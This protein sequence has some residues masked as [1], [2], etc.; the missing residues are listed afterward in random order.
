MPHCVEVAADAAKIN[1]FEVPGGYAM[2]VTFAGQARS[3]EVVLRG[4]PGF[5]DRTR[6]EALH[7]G[8]KNP[9]RLTFSRDGA[10]VVLTVPLYRGC[11][12]VYITDDVSAQEKTGRR[13]STL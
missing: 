8:V 4:L 6:I 10:T 12:M 7:P 5:S 9:T 2:P 11:A 13:L 3:V 1:L